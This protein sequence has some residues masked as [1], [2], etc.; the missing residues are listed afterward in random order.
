MILP[1]VSRATSL[2]VTI[3]SPVTP[4][5]L[6]VIEHSDLDAL[7]TPVGDGTRSDCTKAQCGAVAVAVDALNFR[8]TL[9]PTTRVLIIYL[10]YN[11]NARNGPTDQPA[12]DRAAFATRI[13]D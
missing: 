4:T 6:L 8:I 3:N 2:Q 5:E 13:V 10:A 11:V 7:G 1:E 9:S 12:S